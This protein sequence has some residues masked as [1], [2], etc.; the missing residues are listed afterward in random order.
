MVTTRGPENRRPAASKDIIDLEA[1]PVTTKRPAK[2]APINKI[3]KKIVK[4]ALKNPPPPKST[5]KKPTKKIGK[6]K[7][8]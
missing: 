5:A 3:V 2:P 6:R 4:K 1:S 7:K 8:Y